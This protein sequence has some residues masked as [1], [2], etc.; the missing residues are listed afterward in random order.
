MDQATSR[1][2]D[3]L[4]HWEG[5]VPWPYLD[6]ADEPNVT[7]GIGCLVDSADEL[8][9]L[10]M[11]RWADGELA[12]QGEISEAFTRLRFMSGGLRP[13]AYRGRYYLAES[14]VDALAL[15]HLRVLRAGLTGVFLRF[16]WLPDPAQACLVDLGWNVGAAGMRS[17][18]CLRVAL[19]SSPPD[20][21]RAAENCTTANPH[22]LVM[23]AARN[24]WRVSC[25]EAARVGGATPVPL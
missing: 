7:I 15:E 5:R 13:A 9:A 19:A 8:R 20:W 6:S 2:L 16:E 22:G 3:A 25:M 24:A 10:P 18:R 21:L 23:R 1:Q 11:R 12:T 14:D 17:W 4:A